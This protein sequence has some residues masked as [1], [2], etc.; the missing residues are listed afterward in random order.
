VIAQHNLKLARAM[1][2]KD[3][4]KNVLLIDETNN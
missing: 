3:A 2:A 4:Q 1:P